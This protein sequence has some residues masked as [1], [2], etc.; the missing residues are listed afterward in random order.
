MCLHWHALRQLNVPVVCIHARHAKAAL[1]MQ[2]N[3]TD[4]NDAYGLAQM[5]RCGWYREVEVKS[6]ESHRV[7]LLLTARNRFVSLSVTLYNQIRGLIKTF[8]VVLPP[9]KGGDPKPENRSK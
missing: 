2:L 9:G 6:R 8:G 1:M 5:V 4:Q 7:R 3:N